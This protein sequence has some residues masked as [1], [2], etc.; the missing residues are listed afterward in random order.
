MAGCI[1]Q[2]YKKKMCFVLC[3]REE[4]CSVYKVS[5]EEWEVFCMF[6]SSYLQIWFAPE[7]LLTNREA[8]KYYNI[9]LFFYLM[10]WSINICVNCTYF[11]NPETYLIIPLLNFYTHSNGHH[12]FVKYNLMGT[13]PQ[14]SWAYKNICLNVPFSV[15][16]RQWVEQVWRCLSTCL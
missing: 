2:R 16:S 6:V 3:L 7:S 10:L 8:V 4:M 9:F 1:G 5:I 13:K 12:K 11:S 15:K 14:F